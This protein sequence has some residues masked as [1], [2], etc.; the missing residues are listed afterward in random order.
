MK[1]ILLCLFLINLFL[2]GNGQKAKIEYGFQSGLNI[3]T[4]YGRNILKEH[5]AP[6]T[7]LHIGGHIKINKTEN[8]GFKLIMS[9]DQIGWKYTSLT[10]E[11]NSSSTGLVTVDVIIKLNY[12]NMPV[13]AEYSFGK[14]VK[15]NR[16]RLICG[17]SAE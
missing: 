15:I 16:R 4:A 7:G 13:L 11:S 6:L 10:F 3:S 17:I 9:Y 1:Q 8:W 2:V 12:L 5:K 14:K